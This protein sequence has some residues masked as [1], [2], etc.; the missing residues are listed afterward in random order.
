ME[1]YRELID[2]LDKQFEKQHGEKPP[3]I[4]IVI[5]HGKG[6]LVIRE[7][8]DNNYDMQGEIIERWMKEQLK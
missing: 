2:T 7:T 3:P 5:S 8:E 6:K 1:Q 4:V